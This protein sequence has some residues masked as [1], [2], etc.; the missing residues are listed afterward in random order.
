[1][2]GLLLVIMSRIQEKRRKTFPSIIMLN[3]RDYVT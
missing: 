1:M 3:H 2:K